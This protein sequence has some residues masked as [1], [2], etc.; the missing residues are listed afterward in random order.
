M[1]SEDDRQRILLGH[2]KSAWLRVQGWIIIQD[3]PSYCWG[4]KVLGAVGHIHDDNKSSYFD[5][6]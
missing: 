3:E 5:R 2:S 1:V 4:V 6:V